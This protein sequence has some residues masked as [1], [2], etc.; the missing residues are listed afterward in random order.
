MRSMK[1]LRMKK[2]APN[3]PSNTTISEFPDLSWWNWYD[4]EELDE[5]EE[6]IYDDEEDEEEQGDIKW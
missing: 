4:E 1:F 6:Y 2:M 3:Q 5:D